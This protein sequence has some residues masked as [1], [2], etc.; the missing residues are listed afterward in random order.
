VVAMMK[1]NVSIVDED[2]MM[3]IMKMRMTTNQYS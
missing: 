3:M 2:I 1:T